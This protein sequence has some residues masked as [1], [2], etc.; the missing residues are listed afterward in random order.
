MKRIDFTAFLASIALAL[1]PVIAGKADAADKV[2]TH[3]AESGT[4]DAKAGIRVPAGFKATV[5]ADL[6]APVRH[7]AIAEDGTVYA[8][9]FRA[10]EGEWVA[11][12]QDRDGDGISDSIT[13][14]GSFGGTGI[15]LY[16]GYLYVSSD[17]LIGRYK[18]GDTPVPD[19]APE[20]I[21]SGFPEQNQHATK[22]MVF[23]GKGNMLV[24]VGA[25]SNACQERARTPG[26]PG[27]MPCPQLDLQAGIWRFDAKKPG[28]I[29]GQDSTRYATGIR[30]GLALDWN[31]AADALYVISHGRDQLNQL[32][33]QYYSAEQSAELPAEEFHRV[34]EGSNLGWPYAYWNHIENTHIKAPE[35]GGDGITQVE[36]GLYPEP[37]AAF[38]G[39]WAP[40]DLVFYTASSF[41]EFFHNGAFIAFHGSWNRAP[42]P[43]KGYNVAF[44]P[45]DESGAVTGTPLI[46][47]DHFKGTDVLSS[48]RA[49]KHRPTGLAIGPDGALYIAD[50]AAG[51]IWKV[52][53]DPR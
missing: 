35:Y 23:D 39:H 5:F 32:F 44:I 10:K 25:P 33:P 18:L 9:F 3:A 11:A 19:G 13:R 31:K 12:L 15:A 20:I 36:N 34:D 40:N 24:T 51:Y 47:A 37:L 49:A 6:S 8:S 50:D 22:P 2:Q 16:Q 41:P 21:A 1:S 42:L 29:H 48:P 46:F 43:Q 30:N 26:S 28:Q 14:F 52:S 4:I 45:M 17:T 7:M 38:P 27:L 53:Y